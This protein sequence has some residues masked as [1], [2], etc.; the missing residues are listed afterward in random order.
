MNNKNNSELKNKLGREIWL[1][2]QWLSSIDG[3]AGE[4]Q[5]RIRSAYEECIRIRQ[6]QLDEL[7][8][9]NIPMLTEKSY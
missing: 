8:N 7:L 4:T 6:N 2:E 5:E 9:D 1:F 3:E